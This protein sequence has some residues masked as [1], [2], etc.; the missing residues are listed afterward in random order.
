MKT[1]LKESQYLGVDKYDKMRI[2]GE[3]KKDN[4]LQL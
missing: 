1:Y 2:M 4:E 3:P